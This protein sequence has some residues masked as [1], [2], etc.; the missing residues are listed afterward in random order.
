MD[1]QDLLHPRQ[2]VIDFHLIFQQ[3]RLRENF[4][5]SHG[6]KDIEGNSKSTVSGMN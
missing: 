1:S 6:D 4:V 3:K 5:A 2:H